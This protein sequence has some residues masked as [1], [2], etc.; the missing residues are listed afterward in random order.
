MRKCSTNKER[1][2][3]QKHCNEWIKKFNNSAEFKDKTVL[4]R[5]Y[6]CPDC[7]TWHATSHAQIEKVDSKAELINY[8]ESKIEKQLI[9]LEKKAARIAKLKTEMNFLLVK[10]NE[11]II[12]DKQLLKKISDL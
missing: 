5:S 12:I 11:L 3:T 6:L 7:L 1:F 4:L 10:L 8:V 2:G 9:L